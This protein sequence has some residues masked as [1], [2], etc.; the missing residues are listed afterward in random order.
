[1]IR[2]SIVISIIGTIILVGTSFR[3]GISYNNNNNGF[4]IK[5]KI[6][7]SMLRSISM[8]NNNDDNERIGVIIVDH[9]SK[10]EEAN[11]MLF[12]V[13]EKYK[14]FSY[15]NI[16][17]G[18][19]MELAQPSISVAFKKC[20]DQGATFVICHPFFLSKGRHVQEDIP[21]LMKEA[22][23]INN[24]IK[25]KITEPLGVQDK[26]LELIDTAINESKNSIL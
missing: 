3:L 23:S 11:N 12:K 18:A 21:A 14:S 7:N 22:S 1:M 8:T 17:E 9:G 4:I 2:I 13:V 25:Y 19:H 5:R 16:V 6:Y 15:H 26:I 10:R 24:N 20:V